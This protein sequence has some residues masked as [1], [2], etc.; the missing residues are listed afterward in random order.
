MYL[1]I[2]G[3]ELVPLEDVV[4]F[5]DLSTMKPGELRRLLKA[6]RR[7]GAFPEAAGEGMKSLVVCR[8]RIRLSPISSAT[9]KQRAGQP[10]LSI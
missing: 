7:S 8:E 5:I 9:L 3:D 1:H 2:G 4:A 6:H 10:L